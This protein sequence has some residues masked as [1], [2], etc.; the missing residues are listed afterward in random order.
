[1]IV[2]T[3]RAPRRIY[4][5]PMRLGTR[6]TLISLAS[7]AV[8]TC[9]LAG[10][11][12][13]VTPSFDS[14]E[15]AARNAAIVR[16]AETRDQGSVDELIAMLAS[17]DPATRVLAIRTLERITGQTNDY[18]PHADELSRSAAVRR[19]HAWYATHHTQHAPSVGGRK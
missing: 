2:N 6:A 10:C 1:M 8:L 14:P 11:G 4:T 3:R 16:A 18:D 9:P 17:D 15:P 7:L 19:W 5:S 13:V 12:P